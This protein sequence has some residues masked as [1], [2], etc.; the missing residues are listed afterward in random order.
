MICHLLSSELNFCF[1]KLLEKNSFLCKSEN[2]R[3][4]FLRP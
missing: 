4:D 1:D 3:R 2:L